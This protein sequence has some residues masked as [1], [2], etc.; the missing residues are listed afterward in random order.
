MFSTVF[1]NVKRLSQ[2]FLGTNRNV[3]FSKYC[4]K[5][6]D[7]FME[8]REFVKM[9]E[10]TGLFSSGG[11]V[12]PDPLRPHNCDLYNSRHCG[13]TGGAGGAVMTG[14]GAPRMK[15]MQKK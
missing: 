14:G 13:G 5:Y 11:A 7:I 10:D 3:P 12:T 8:F 15:K 4:A 2:K 6:I 1:F 9:L